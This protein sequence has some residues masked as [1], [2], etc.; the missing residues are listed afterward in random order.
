MDDSL[1]VR[2]LIEILKLSE[3]YLKSKGVQSARIESE[4]ILQNVLGLS[5]IDLYLNFDRPISKDEVEKIRNYISR[6]GKKEPIQ[7]ILGKTEFMG[8]PFI[9]T[10]KVL[11][12]RSDTEVIVEKAIEILK[13]FKNRKTKVLDIGTGSGNIAIS[14]AKYCTG[15]QI[16]AIDITL[17]ILKVARENAKLNKV[18]D[19][20]RFIEKNFLKNSDL[21]ET[22][23][24]I[25]SNPPYIGNN[26]YENLPEEIKQWEPKIALYPGEDELIFYKAITNSYKKFLKHN[27]H[28][29]VEIGGDYQL[30]NVKSIF[31]MANLNVIETIFDYT[32]EARGIIAKNIG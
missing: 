1:R 5:R 12:P 10:P 24:L 11:I 19:S 13:Q 6:R 4:W 32:G 25:I 28:I 7:Y 18:E 23:D 3:N 31:E 30:K 26:H 9:V 20:I 21:D 15:T 2:T 17:D 16:T 22:F 27:G 8:L 14:I 29:V